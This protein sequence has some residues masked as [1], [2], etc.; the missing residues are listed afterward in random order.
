MRRVHQRLEKSLAKGLPPVISLRRYAVGKPPAS[1]AQWIV[2]DAHFVT[3]TAILRKLD[4]Q[5]RAFPVSYIDPW[6]GKRCQGVIRLPDRPAFA[7]ASGNAYC[8][9]ADFPQAS[10]GKGRGGKDGPTFLAVSA[11]MGRW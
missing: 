8:L 7:D 1:V 4:K 9:E 3:L 5:A 10:V 11:A 2:V 6:G